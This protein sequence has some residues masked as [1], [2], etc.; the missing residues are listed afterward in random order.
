MF[1]S[2]NWSQWE[3]YGEKE[4]GKKTAKVFYCQFVHPLRQMFSRRW[5]KRKQKNDNNRVDLLNL[6]SPFYCS[7]SFVHLNINKWKQKINFKLYVIAT[8]YAK[9]TSKKIL[10]SRY[11][12]KQLKIKASVHPFYD[13]GFKNHHILFSI[14]FFLLF[15][16][17][18]LLLFEMIRSEKT[19][20]LSARIDVIY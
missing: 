19:A 3:A 12:P 10:S 17:L 11:N 2:L 4:I 9:Q 6:M 15:F 14:F 8:Y 1:I 20:R 7:F 5:K 16:F 13:Y 18:S